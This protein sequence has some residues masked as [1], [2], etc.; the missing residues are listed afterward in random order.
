MSMTSTCSSRT[1]MH[2]LRIGL[3]FTTHTTIRTMGTRRAGGATLTCGNTPVD[4]QI[5]ISRRMKAPFALKIGGSVYNLVN[6]EHTCLGIMDTTSRPNPTHSKS[7]IAMA[8]AIP[9][10]SLRGCQLPRIAQVLC[11]PKNSVTKTGIP[12]NSG[13]FSIIATPREGI[14]SESSSPTTIKIM[15]PLE[16]GGASPTFGRMRVDHR[17]A[18]PIRAGELSTSTV[19]GRNWKLVHTRHICL[20]TMGIR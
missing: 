11:R 12:K 8:M 3:E 10:E 15:A 2:N 20:R 16:H 17:I 1:A 5:V 4:L 13:Y 9:Q 18:T 19:G 7:A 14:G 6:I